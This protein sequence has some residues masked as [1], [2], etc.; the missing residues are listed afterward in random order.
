[1]IFNVKNRILHPWIDKYLVWDDGKVN[2]NLLGKG[3]QSIKMG[4]KPTNTVLG[5]HMEMA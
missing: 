1:M 2:Q 4:F 3:I 5:K